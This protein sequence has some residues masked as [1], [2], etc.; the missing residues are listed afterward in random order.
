VTPAFALANPKLECDWRKTGG[1]EIERVFARV[2]VD[3]RTV[4]MIDQWF[5][6]D[7]DCDCAEIAT[8]SVFCAED[9]AW[10]GNLQLLEPL[11]AIF[12]NQA[13]TG[14]INANLQRSA[15]TQE[16]ARTS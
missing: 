13:W 6:V 12:T 5:A 7:R 3:R 2:D 15:R 4:E 14:W 16:L 10:S 11:C 9:Q 8:G 1:L